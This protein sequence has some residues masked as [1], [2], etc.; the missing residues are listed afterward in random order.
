MPP[1]FAAILRLK[2]YSLVH[3]CDNDVEK[4][5]QELIREHQYEI[6]IDCTKQKKIKMN[7]KGMKR[8]IINLKKMALTAQNRLW[9]VP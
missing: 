3:L 8:S 4:I 7:F 5:T 2:G 1:K 9:P 6:F